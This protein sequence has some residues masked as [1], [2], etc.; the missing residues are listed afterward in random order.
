MNQWSVSKQVAS[1]T[2][3]QLINR[4]GLSVIYEWITIWRNTCD[5]RECG[6]CGSFQIVIVERVVGG[7][8]TGRSGEAAG[9]RWRW[10]HLLVM[11]IVK[12]FIGR[13]PDDSANPQRNVGRDQ[14]HK[15]EP[16]HQSKFLHHHLKSFKFNY[17]FEIQHLT[18]NIKYIMSS[19]NFY[20]YH[21]IVIDTSELTNR[22]C[23]C[24]K[25]K[26]ACKI[27]WAKRMS[28]THFCSMVACMAISNPLKI[29]VANPKTVDKEKIAWYW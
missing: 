26:R 3:L 5:G 14:V 8:Q 25:V 7:R 17:F 11:Q 10:R 21:L 2:L 24:R 23:I 16:S 6:R 9:R 1:F 27:G 22:K 15:T 12:P 19:Q 4:L 18:F 29:K 13:F 28:A 20:C